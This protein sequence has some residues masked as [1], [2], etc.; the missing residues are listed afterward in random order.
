MGNIR[1]ELFALVERAAAALVLPPVAQVLIADPRPS[2]ERDAEFGLLALTDGA[3]GLYYAWLGS[4]QAAMPARFIAD[5]FA[6]R[7]VLE[8]ARLALADDD[9][10]RS[11][12]VAAINA[13]TAHVHAQAGFVPASASDSFGGLVLERHDRLGM[14]GNFPPLVRRAR[15]LGVPTFVV[16]RK[17]HMVS[18]SA[19]L[20]IS[21][22]PTIL[23]GCTKIICTGAT[24]L[25]DSL[26]QM[27]AHCR[28]AAQLALV[29]PTVGFF[30]DAVFA[31]GVD[32]VAGTRIIDPA[33]AYA[34]LRAGAK[35][36]D[37]AERTVIRRAEYPGFTVLLERARMRALQHAGAPSAHA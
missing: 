36:G 5:S 22:D 17:A 2:P 28:S 6:G 26:D 32:V 24:L 33:L 3:A 11:V 8:L 27:L 31:R 30:P 7:P 25:N 15:K 16:E 14:I 20:V 21:L 13:V 23:L 19:G 34:R 35:L 4:S 1:A 29:G 37:S 9:G 12:G 18:A 10:A